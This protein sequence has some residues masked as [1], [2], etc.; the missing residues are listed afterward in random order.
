[1]YKNISPNLNFVEEEKKIKEIFN[2][3]REEIEANSVECG[4]ADIIGTHRVRTLVNKAE[5]MWKR[6]V[7]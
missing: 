7:D 6:G 5:S 3:L 4:G 1:M 2:W